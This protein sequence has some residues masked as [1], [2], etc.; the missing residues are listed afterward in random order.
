M[1]FKLVLENYL[2]NPFRSI[3][4]S[5]LVA[6]LAS[7]LLVGGFLSQSLSKGL[8]QISGIQSD[9]LQMVVWVIGSF[10]LLISVAA[11]ISTF[12][13]TV[14]EKRKEYALLRIVGYTQRRVRNLVLGEAAFVTAVGIALG[15][16]FSSVAYFVFKI[17][18]EEQPGL[19]LLFP[20]EWEFALTYLFVIVFLL[21]VGTLSVYK[22]ANGIA[23]SEVST[24]LREEE[25]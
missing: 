5:L 8:E 16:L 9:I 12:V 14:R 4:L 19:L 3:T 13:L 21:L 20:E 25:T 1:N 11:I 17:A 18:V 2:R 7:A 23:R 10:F 6:I 24:I 22:I 15:F